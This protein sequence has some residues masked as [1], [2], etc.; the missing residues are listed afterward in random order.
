MKCGTSS[1]FSYLAGHPEVCPSIC[2]E[3][4]YFSEKFK[5]ANVNR[6]EELWSFDKSTHKYALEASTGYTKYPADTA[7]PRNIYNYG[8][9]PKFIYLVR[10]PIDR[11]NSHIAYMNQSDSPLSADYLEYLISVSSYHLQLEQYR[12]YFSM[13]NFLVL[14][15][16]ELK[17]KPMD[18]INRVYHFLGLSLDYYPDSY[19]AVNTTQ[20]ESNAEHT[21]RSSIAGPLIKLIPKHVKRTVKK[22]LRKLSSPRKQILT[23][24]QVD[25]VRSALS[26]EMCKLSNDYGVNVRKWGFESS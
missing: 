4:E 11:I 1:L 13:D 2:K 20:V 15:F 8:I 10:N 12:K 25:F 9:K 23:D 6:Y 18:S 26:N 14:D 5:S 7:A 22:Q 19:T 3:P 21:L 24:E 16:N 17:N